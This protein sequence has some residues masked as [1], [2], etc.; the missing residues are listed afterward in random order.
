MPA[1][2]NLVAASEYHCLFKAFLTLLPAGAWHVVAAAL[3]LVS[4]TFDGPW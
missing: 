1:N 3:A 2:H 4:L